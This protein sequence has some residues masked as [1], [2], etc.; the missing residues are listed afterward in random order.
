MSILWT[1]IL[2]LSLIGLAW[3]LYLLTT[4][5]QNKVVWWQIL[6]PVVGILGAMNGTQSSI[7]KLLDL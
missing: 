1:F 4:N 7:R 6:L 3:N 5:V 2:F